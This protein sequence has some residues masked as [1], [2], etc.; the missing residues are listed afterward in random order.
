MKHIITLILISGFISLKAQENTSGPSANSAD[1]LL[2]S[3]RNFHIGGYGEINYNQQLSADM[4]HN[5]SLDVH[6]LVLLFGYQFNERT[7]FITEIEF[8]HVKEVYVEQAFL[9]YKLND[10]INFRGGL[11]LIPMGLTNEYHEPPVYFGVERPLIDRYISP[12]TWREA[13]FGFNGNILAASIKYQLYLVNGFKGYDGEALLD[14]KNGFRKGRQK[15]AESIMS[16]PDITGK[17]EYYGIA[18]LNL[19]LSLYSGKTRSNLYDGISKSDAATMAT[20]DSSAVGLHMLGIDGRYN[21]R[22]LKLKTQLYLASVSNTDQ[23]NVFTANGGTENDLGSAMFGYYIEGGYN[24]LRSFNTEI[25]FSPFARYSRYNMH[26]RTA[27]SLVANPEYNQA[28]ITTGL[29]LELAR[30]AVIK[31]DLQF[32]KNE[33]SGSFEKFINAGIGIMF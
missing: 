15:G 9:Q 13:G 10:F 20:A 11:L 14:G 33:A 19:G 3:E 28:V 23:Y 26:A 4:L 24:V 5:G 17:I 29:N 27:G 8:E 30:G 21:H 31:T 32:L 1:K 6:R 2:E 18:G 7:R 16:T 22:G 12:T 25:E